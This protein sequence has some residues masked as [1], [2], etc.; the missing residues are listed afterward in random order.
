[1]R[2]D[3]TA[4]QNRQWEKLFL[5]DFL[6]FLRDLKVND[7]KFLSVCSRLVSCLNVIYIC[8][9]VWEICFCWGWIGI[10][11]CSTMSGHWKN[12][13]HAALLSVWNAVLVIQ[14]RCR[15]QTVKQRVL[16]NTLLFYVRTVDQHLS[17]NHKAKTKQGPPSPQPHPTHQAIQPVGSLI[18]K[19]I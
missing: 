2:Q 5:E 14:P 17:F 19:T 16:I 3:T 12:N 15:L 7:V 4:N 1:M 10:F 9:T 18:K 8:T 13:P 6:A 11:S